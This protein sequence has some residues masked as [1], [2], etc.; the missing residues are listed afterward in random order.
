MFSNLTRKFWAINIAL[1][2]L[3]AWPQLAAARTRQKKS[4]PKGSSVARKQSQDTAKAKR[5]ANPPTTPLRLNDPLYPLDEEGRLLAQELRQL[6]TRD[7]DRLVSVIKQATITP[8]SNELP[9]T[10]MLA[11]AHA[12]TNGRILIVS[13]AGAVGLAQATPIAYLSEGLQGRLFLTDDYIRG[14]RAYFMKKPLH[15]ADEIASLLLEGSGALPRLAAR[16]LLDSAFKYRGEG[17][18]E[19]RILAPHAGPDFLEQ[20][21]NDEE[22]NLVLLRDLESML[23]RGAD[24]GELKEFRDHVRDRYRTLRAVQTTAWKRY[25]RELTAERDALLR[26][27]YSMEPD[28]VMRDR[29]YESS[30]FLARELDDRFS[31]R[32]MARFLMTH[33]QTKLDEARELGRAEAELERMTAGLYNG[34]AHNIKRMLVGLIV[35]LP[36]TQNYMRKVPATK[37]RLDR[38]LARHVRVSSLEPAKSIVVSSPSA[39]ESG[40]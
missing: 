12:E 23:D 28:D 25:Q 36:E 32:S 8:P 18:S 21:R 17:V 22:D 34:G 33:L 27:H 9:L 38:T 10:M 40:Y 30:E 11:I 7:A 3:L 29:A 14:A 6:W 37:N 26:R 13:E 1:G 5:S 19:L 39:E 4:S 16:Q 31:P 15:D 20:L 2:C 35:Q 24:R